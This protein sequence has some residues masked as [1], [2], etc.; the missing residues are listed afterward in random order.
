M[1][2]MLPPEHQQAELA[3]IAA[4]TR[5]SVFGNFETAVDNIRQ[6][7]LNAQLS[8]LSAD[9]NPDSNTDKSAPSWTGNPLFTAGCYVEIGKAVTTTHLNGRRVRLFEKSDT[10][11]V[12]IIRV[13]GK[14]SGLWKCHER[15]L[16]A[17]PIMQQARARPAS[18]EVGFLDLSLIH[19]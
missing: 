5:V 16:Q 17:L 15:F 18:H 9:A 14:N 2:K 1:A 4:I 12:W 10:P 6:D 19:I 11:N 8:A 7:E 13:L 3:S